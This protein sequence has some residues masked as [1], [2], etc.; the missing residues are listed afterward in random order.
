[1][2]VVPRGETSP[3]RSVRS[4]KLVKKDVNLRAEKAP[5]ASDA[6]A[7]T[8]RRT[9]SATEREGG[10]DMVS[11]IEGIATANG[12]V[13]RS[14]TERGNETGTAT[15]SANVSGTVTVTATAIAETRRIATA[16]AGRTASLAEGR[17]LRLLLLLLMLTTADCLVDQR[18]AAD[19]AGMSLL[20]SDVGEVTTRYVTIASDVSIWNRSFA[21]LKADRSSKRSSRKDS[22]HEDRSRRSSEKDGHERGGRDSERRRRDRDAGDAEVK[23]LSIDTKV[24]LT[25]RSARARALT[26]PCASLAVG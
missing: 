9:V 20:G 26:K 4:A 3:T 7:K 13:T 17:Q 19:T 18:L 22:H 21:E 6:P 12:T 8:E 25:L 2:T 10:T 24:N 14:A 1:M 5:A 15:G 11:A 23:G 16:R